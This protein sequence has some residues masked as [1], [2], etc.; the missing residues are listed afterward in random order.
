M[1]YVLLFPDGR[2]GSHPNIALAGF[3]YNEDMEGQRQALTGRGRS[4]RVTLNQFYAYLFHVRREEHLF[5]A[6]RLFQQLIVDGYACTED[7]RLNFIVQHQDD[8]RVDI[9]QGAQ[10]ALNRGDWMGENKL[11]QVISEYICC[12]LS[13]V[14]QQEDQESLIQAVYP[15]LHTRTIVEREFLCERAILAPH[16]EMVGRINNKILEMLPGA[17]H[18]HRSADSISSLNGRL[19]ALN[20]PNISIFMKGL[21]FQSVSNQTGSVATVKHRENTHTLFIL[22]IH[23]LA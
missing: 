15:L 18:E 16:N 6:G 10:D 14:I 5:R 4:K 11:P 1:H 13:M 7:N 19:V 21:H 8:L 23:V 20:P 2:D 3:N 17:F 12:P 9:Y 22:R